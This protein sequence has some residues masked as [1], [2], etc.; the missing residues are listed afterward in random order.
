MSFS[1]LVSKKYL[2]DKE[3]DRL[4]VLALR[5]EQIALDIGG[6]IGQGGKVR[7][8]LSVGNMKLGGTQPIELFDAQGDP[9]VR[10]EQN[11]NAFFGD[12]LRLPESTSLSIFAVD[13]TYNSE[14]FGEGDVMLGDNST[15]KANLLWDKSAG[16]LIFRGDTTDIMTIDGENDRIGIGTSAPGVNLHVSVA[17]PW[18][19]NFDGTGNTASVVQFINKQT[20]NNSNYYDHRFLFYNDAGTPELWDAIIIRADVVDITD[21]SEDARIEFQTMLAGS[22]AARFYVGNGFYSAGS[23]GGLGAGTINIEGKIMTN[24]VQIKEISAAGG[25]TASYGQL[26]VKDDAPCVLMFTDDG[27]A[28]YTV[29]VTA[30]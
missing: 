27:G 30:V 16:T 22:R 12:N 18:V 3:R 25:D 8:S 11:G 28:D 9:T 15:D 7:S 24:T 20:A 1:E 26:W 21:G 23:T 4:R 6:R 14:D 5:L 29:D 17:G 19:A 13:T 10:L 2:T